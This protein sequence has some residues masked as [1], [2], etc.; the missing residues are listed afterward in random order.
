[1][2]QLQDAIYKTMESYHEI[3]DD[4]S[5]CCITDTMIN[6][7]TLMLRESFHIIHTLSLT[8]VTYLIS[9]IWDKNLQ[10]I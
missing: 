4:V 7:E 9:K 1:M 3:P 5:D 6:I 8:W 2:T 10:N